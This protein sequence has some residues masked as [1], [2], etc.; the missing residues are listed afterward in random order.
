MELSASQNLG[1]NRRHQRKATVLPE[2]EDSNSGHQDQPW[3]YCDLDTNKQPVKLDT[4]TR[5]RSRVREG[6]LEGSEV[7]G[8]GRKGI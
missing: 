4:A 5:A 2:V 6:E 7:T 8:E 3:L 1:A